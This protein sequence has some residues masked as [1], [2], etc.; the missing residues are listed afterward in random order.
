V[1][2]REIAAGNGIGHPLVQKMMGSF[3]LLGSFCLLDSSLADR[4]AQFIFYNF[5]LNACWMS[6]VLMMK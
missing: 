5:V 3:G 6:F 2:V 4:G 1:T